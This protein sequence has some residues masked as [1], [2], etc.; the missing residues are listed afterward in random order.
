MKKATS[1]AFNTL[2]S[3]AALRSAGITNLASGASG[4]ATL[5]AANTLVYFKT[6]AGKYGCMFVL[7]MNTVANGAAK[8]N[9][10]TVEVKVEK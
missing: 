4:K 1:P 2:T 6:A 3:A 5:L 8:E 9:Y 10:M 7:S